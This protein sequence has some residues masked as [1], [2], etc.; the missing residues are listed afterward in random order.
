MSNIICTLTFPIS[1]DLCMYV[2]T[3]VLK[4]LEIVHT[5][6]SFHAKHY[7]S[8]RAKLCC[9]IVD[10]EIYYVRHDKFKSQ[11]VRKN[12]LQCDPFSSSRGM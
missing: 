7:S 9:I 2:P 4:I 8:E 3:C 12:K 10:V 5:I 6:F 1:H 11:V